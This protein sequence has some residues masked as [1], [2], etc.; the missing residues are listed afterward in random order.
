MMKQLLISAIFALLLLAQPALA[1]DDWL[2]N[3]Y[4]SPSPDR[5][6]EEIRILSSQGIL[7]DK[8]SSNL[9]GV[10]LSQVFLANQERIPDWMKQ[11]KDLPESDQ[12]TLKMALWLSNNIAAKSYLSS[13]G[14][15]KL[16]ENAPPDILAYEPTSPEVLDMWWAY[17][18]ATGKREPIEKIISAFNYSEYEG[19]VE[20]YQSGN[21]SEE[22]KKKVIYELTFQAA[23]WSLE[24]NMS[25]HQKVAEI[26]DDIFWNAELS[27]SEKLWLGA[28]LVKAVPGK[29]LMTK[30]EGGQTIERIK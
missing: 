3:Y 12:D 7:R 27:N 20:S 22:T 2:M 4:R 25:Q 21:K 24:S 14:D 8:K 5:F 10:F 17:F 28:V 30:T 15:E 6:V 26:A 19:S 13:I 11:L 18:F 16:A 29:Y 1:A 23:R 9:I